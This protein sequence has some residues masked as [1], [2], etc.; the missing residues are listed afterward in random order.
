M[1]A[2]SHAYRTRALP[3]SSATLRSALGIVGFALLL[4]LGAHLRV[5]LPGTPVPMTLQTLFVLL[6]PLALG[7]V[8]GTAAVT[9]YLALGLT[10]WPVFALGGGPTAGYL[11]G[12]FLAQPVIGGLAGWTGGSWTRLAGALLLGN[13]AIFA[14]GL[15]GLALWLSAG[16]Q[17]PTL[18]FVLGL[19]LAPFAPGI[20]LKTALATLIG[21]KL[22]RGRVTQ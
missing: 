6:A 3:L 2:N 17:T 8:G 22:L 21:W 19:G 10:G 7:T 13:L 20:V 18:G 12:F 14:A 5:W 4:T 9:L 15:T 11:V 16:G 1:N